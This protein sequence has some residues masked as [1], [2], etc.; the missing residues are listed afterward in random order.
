MTR[1]DEARTKQAYRRGIESYVRANQLGTAIMLLKSFLRR[2]PQ[3][4]AKRRT[5]QMVLAHAKQQKNDRAVISIIQAA[6]LRTQ[7][8][9]MA[10]QWTRDLAKA[11][12][13][14]GEPTKA[15]ATYLGF[16]KGSNPLDHKIKAALAAI[17][18]ETKKGDIRNLGPVLDFISVVKVR[19]PQLQKQLVLFEVAYLIAHG[20]LSQFARLEQ[21][22][23]PFAVQDVTAQNYLGQLRYVLADE[24]AKQ[25]IRQTIPRQNSMGLAEMTGFKTGL[26]A[27]KQQFE[28]V[29]GIPS[30]HCAAARLKIK[31]YAD[32][33]HLRLSG[34]SYSQ[35][36]ANN[37]KQ[38][39]SRKRQGLL[40]FLK[41]TGDDSYAQA[42][43]DAKQGHTTRAWRDEIIYYQP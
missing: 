42:L 9:P 38:A 12:E 28:A 18:L 4:P 7:S 41:T 11:Y 32:Q 37:A 43:V 35:Q 33:L 27:V 20:K 14:R 5:V 17:D 6:M 21:K 39:W 31:Q 30:H 2:Y 19:D 10:W 34:A 16:L 26:V 36:L 29:C 13:Q 40:A 25:V 8:D 1:A 15:V 22:L 3:D 24:R 23:R